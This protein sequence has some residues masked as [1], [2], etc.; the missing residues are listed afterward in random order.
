VPSNQVNLTATVGR[1]KIAGD[2]GVS[3]SSK[4]EIGIFF[5]M[6]SGPKVLG[7]TVRW[8]SAARNPVQN[9]NRDVSK[10]AGEHG[11][12]APASRQP[13]RR[14][15]CP[16]DIRGGGDAIRSQIVDSRNWQRCDGRHN[17]NYFLNQLSV[18][19]SPFTVR[20]VKKKGPIPG[21][22]GPSVLQKEREA[23]Y[24]AGWM[25]LTRI[26]LVDWSRVPLTVTCLPLNCLAF[27]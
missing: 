8:K 4:I 20:F 21:G 5:A 11:F 19:S 7:S 3:M 12:V 16:P 15:G 6:L 14:A 9:A 10:T 23:R 2:H 26:M 22:T 25:S 17:L 13:D 27:V 1:T 24:E 18:P